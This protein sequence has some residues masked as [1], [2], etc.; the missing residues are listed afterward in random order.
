MIAEIQSFLTSYLLPIFYW[1][2]LRRHLRIRR[3]R[4]LLAIIVF[5]TSF[6][7][8]LSSVLHLRPGAH[9]EHLYSTVQWCTFR[10]FVFHLLSILSG[11]TRALILVLRLLFCI[12]TF[13]HGLS[14]LDQAHG[15]S[16]LISI[17]NCLRLLLVSYWNELT[18]TL[19]FLLF[20]LLTSSLWR[21]AFIISLLLEIAC[22]SHF[23]LLVCTALAVLALHAVPLKILDVDFWAV[24]RVLIYSFW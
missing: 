9:L 6:H 15:G 7:D 24:L 20:I 17:I 22:L 5:R 19:W 16:S 12:L 3:Y 1:C 4:R 2:L 23:V 10:I 13:R 8:F 14:R 21:W 11:L 18:Q